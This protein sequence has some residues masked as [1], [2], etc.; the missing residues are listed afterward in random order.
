[1]NGSTVCGCLLA[2]RRARR[3]PGRDSARHKDWLSAAAVTHG[4]RIKISTLALAVREKVQQQLRRVS[5]ARCY[6]LAGDFDSAAP[7][8]SLPAS[9]V[10]V[11]ILQFGKLNKVVS[12]L[13][14]IPLSHNMTS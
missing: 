9:A 4:R 6:S 10:D 1:M 2:G 3:D 12:R 14:S 5:P 8:D 7:F 11:R 13:K